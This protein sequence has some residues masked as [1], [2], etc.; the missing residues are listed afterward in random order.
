[1]KRVIANACS[2]DC[3]CP[4]AILEDGKVTISDPEAPERGSFTMTEEE[5]NNLIKSIDSK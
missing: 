3:C 5:W 2:K 1:M 4:I